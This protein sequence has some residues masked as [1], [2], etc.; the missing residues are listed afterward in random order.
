MVVL[1]SGRTA[2]RITMLKL[3]R[4]ECA[5]HLINKIDVTNIEGVNI[6]EAGRARHVWLL[7][8]IFRVNIR[9]R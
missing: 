9:I 7:K 6:S 2:E 1:S 5:S 4:Y 3:Y 8:R